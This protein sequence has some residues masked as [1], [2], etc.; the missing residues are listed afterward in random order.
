MWPSNSGSFYLRAD[1]HW[2]RNEDVAR[3][4]DCTFILHWRDNL[5]RLWLTKRLVQIGLPLLQHSIHFNRV[6]DI[7]YSLCLIHFNWCRIVQHTFVQYFCDDIGIL[8]ILANWSLHWLRIHFW[9]QQ[10]IEVLIRSLKRL[11]WSNLGL[12]F[13]AWLFKT[14]KICFWKSW[15]C[16]WLKFMQLFRDSW[17]I[18]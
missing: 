6:L 17:F 5:L 16:A 7:W 3:P 13:S 4:F 15:F 11:K 12:T 8:N 10:F 9:D 1:M 14:M 2:F 18:W